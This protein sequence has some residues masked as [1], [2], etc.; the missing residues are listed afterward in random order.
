MECAAQKTSHQMTHRARGFTLIEIGVSLLIVAVTVLA[1]LAL[2][3]HAVKQAVR[4]DVYDNSA[5]VGQMVLETWRGSLTLNNFD[6][7]NAL[8]DDFTISA[9]AA[10]PTTPTGLTTLGTYHIEFS[11]IHYYLT[12]AWQDRSLAGPAVLAVGVG[13]KQNHL[14]GILENTDPRVWLTSCS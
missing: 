11:G 3:F 4:A 12:L 6:P 13:W 14:A 1:A 9:D 5:R 2:K 10:G 8:S 7:I